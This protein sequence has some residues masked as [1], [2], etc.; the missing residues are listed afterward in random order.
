MC[1]V[2]FFFEFGIS[3]TLEVQAGSRWFLLVSLVFLRELGAIQ[4]PAIVR[5]VKR[6]LSLVFLRVLVATRVQT[7]Y[8]MR[9]LYVG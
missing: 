5:L 4:G 6:L 9:L 2:E 3:E 8:S 7:L 1:H